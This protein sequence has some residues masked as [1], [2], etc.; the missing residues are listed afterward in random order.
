ME[1]ALIWTDQFDGDSISRNPML[2]SHSHNFYELSFVIKG[3]LTVLFERKNYKFSGSCAILSPPNAAHHMLVDKGRY[4]RYNI[5]FYKAALDAVLNHSGRVNDLFQTD[6]CAIALTEQ[7]VRRIQFTVELLIGEQSSENRALL[8]G[9]ILNVIAAERKD[10]SS[11]E[12]PASYIEDVMRIILNEYP[13]KLLASELAARCF[14]SRTK[15]M[16]DFKKKTGNTLLEYI[17]FVRL[18]H[19]KDALSSGK[20]IYETAMYCGFVNA[21]NFTKVFKKYFGIPPREYRKLYA[22]ID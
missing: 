18:E 13:T 19:A 4:F 8:L 22:K 15:L 12:L 9:F 5:Y 6:G 10:P 20:S 17:T 7:A 11:S 16:T 3:D 1:K 14:V 2:E 21:A